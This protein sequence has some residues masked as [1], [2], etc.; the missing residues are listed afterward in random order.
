MRRYCKAYQLRDLRQFEG[1]QEKQ[2]ESG[3]PLSDE[4]VCYIWDDFTVV[5][6]PIKDDHPLFDQVTPEWRAFCTTRLHFA[7]PA[8]LTSAQS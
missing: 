1:W 3:E 5:L 8:D 4:E 7:I 6:S 2:N